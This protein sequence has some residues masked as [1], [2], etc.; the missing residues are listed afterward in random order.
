[1]LPTSQRLK[2]REQEVAA[3]V[4]DG[5][6]IIINLANGV[7][8]S[9]DKAGGFIWEMIE[10]KHSLEETVTAL[11]ARYDVSHEQA[12]KDVEQLVGKLLQENLISA[13]EDREPVAVDPLPAPHERL[14]YELP[15]LNIYQDMGDL[16]ALDPPTPGLEDISW[17]EPGETPSETS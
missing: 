14:P 7:Y 9:M 8:Y 11:T 12:Q 4:M 6:A 5:E 16:L 17:T 2:P 10:R 15:T 3:K 1:M 13:S